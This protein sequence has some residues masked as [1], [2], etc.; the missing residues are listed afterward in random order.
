MFGFGFSA[1]LQL[2][3]KIY[4]GFPDDSEAIGEAEDLKNELN[5]FNMTLELLKEQLSEIAVTVD[6]SGLILDPTPADEELTN[7]RLDSF[8]SPLENDVH[9]HLR[10]ERTK[11]EELSWSR[12]SELRTVRELKESIRIQREDLHRS[13]MRKTP[14]HRPKFPL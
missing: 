14:L 6:E 3:Q 7:Q 5:R 8:K 1:V 2:C 11:K 13:V 12:P 4:Q 9:A 10:S